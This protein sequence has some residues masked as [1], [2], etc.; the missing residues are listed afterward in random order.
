MPPIPPLTPP[1]DDTLTDSPQGQPQASAQLVP[2][3]VPATAPGA[4]AAA[5]RAL[6]AAAEKEREKIAEE[7]ACRA[8]HGIPLKPWSEARQR[9][10]DQLVAADVPLPDSAVCDN[11]AFYHGMFP[12]AVKAL[13][14][15]LHEPRDWEPL[16]PRLI[17]HIEAWGAADHIPAGM[18]EA[19]R[20]AFVPERLNVPGDTMQ[21]KADAVNLVMR[22]LNAH[23]EVRAMRRVK[24][25]VGRPDAEGN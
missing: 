6:E 9:L 20:K 19:E 7:D 17:A 24:S 12:M 4:Q 23:H 2:A 18:D 21:E 13:Y 16:R 14:L 22:M 1:S 15:A 11:L 25:R 10:L 8:W 5:Q 3:H